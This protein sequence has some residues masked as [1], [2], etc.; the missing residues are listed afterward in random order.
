[1]IAPVNDTPRHKGQFLIA[2]ETFIRYLFTSVAHF[3]QRRPDLLVHLFGKTCAVRQ[4][5]P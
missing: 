3:I 2:E 1:M 5:T 4:I